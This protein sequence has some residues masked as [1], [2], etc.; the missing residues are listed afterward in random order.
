[1]DSGGHKIC[2]L[3]WHGVSTAYS[4]LLYLREVLSHHNDVKLWAFNPRK[5]M[6]NKDISYFN[7]FSD[8]WYGKIKRFRVYIGRI[9]AFLIA[10]KCDVVIINDLDFFKIGYIAKKWFPQKVIIQYNTEICGSD[11]PY[12]IHAKAFYERHA[13]Y[14]D[15]IIECLKERAD[16]RKETYKI[17]KKIYVINNTIPQSELTNAL[18]AE[19]EID[20]FFKFKN[21]DLPCLVYAGGCSLS[22]NLIDILNCTDFFSDKL[23]FLFFC[24]GSEQ[25]F[26]KVKT[27][28]MQHD[29]CYLYHSVDRI[30]LL[31]V[32]QKCDIGI[33]Y[34]DPNVSVNH[35][36]ASPSK[37][38]EYISVGLN[39]VSSN[40]CGINRMI[41]EYNLGVCFTNEEGIKGGIDRLL[42]KGLNSRENIIK[43]F[44]KH[45]CYEVDSKETI[46]ELISLINR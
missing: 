42:T 28:C 45:F 10:L 23:N 30:T 18:E 11:V 7:S 38:Y 2:I 6:P 39:V 4:C 37:F 26:S 31:N 25:D 22:R 16:Y 14:P 24:H 20:K 44:K 3:T 43:A 36:F 29:N 5:Q 9:H 17:D 34:Y 41:E 27:I 19:V 1:M 15:M 33:Q 40:N 32:L 12:P 8:T 46:Q 13:S 21:P 35:K